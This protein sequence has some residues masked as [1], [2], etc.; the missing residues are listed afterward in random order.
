MAREKKKK[1][2]SSRLE[3]Q[4][5]LQVCVKRNLM[6]LLLLVLTEFCVGSTD[7]LITIG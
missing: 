6:K 5:E 3:G 4:C 7:V 1:K 2:R